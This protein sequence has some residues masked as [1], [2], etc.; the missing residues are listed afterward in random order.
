MAA[1]VADAINRGLKE[2]IEVCRRGGDVIDRCHI[3]VIGYGET[4]HSCFQGSLAKQVWTTPQQLSSA[5]IR[6]EN[7]IQLVAGGPSGEPVER[8]IQFPVW[9]EPR[10]RGSPVIGVA[11]QKAYSALET[12]T[13]AHGHCPP[14]MVVHFTAGR[15]VDVDNFSAVLS[16][17]NVCT[18]AGRAC[19][20]H[21]RLG[22]Q[23]VKRAIF[24]ADEPSGEAESLLYRAASIATEPFL[25]TFHGQTENGRGVILGASHAEV[26][27][28][29]GAIVEM[30]K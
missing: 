7:R 12:W 11:F 26:V 24:P 20:L 25:S 29:I 13:Y 5:P 18:N 16:I 14:P 10:N 9:V 8:R 27:R 3:G 23:G 19:V 2:I 6:V 4:V 21:C 22:Q 17:K 30:L 15:W 1:T 28:L